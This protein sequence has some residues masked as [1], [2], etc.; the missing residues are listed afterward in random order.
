MFKKK[1]KQINTGQVIIPVGHP[2]PPEAHEVDAAYL[3][4][5]HF[6]CK[7]E[8]LL[9]TDDYKRKT[10]DIVMLGTLWEMKSPIGASKSTISNQF[11]VASKQARNII[12]DTRRTALSYEQIEKNVLNEFKMRSKTKRVLLINK[13]EKIIEIQK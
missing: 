11:K 7:V 13:F 2:N 3:L 10:A 1:K 6:N 4:A 8:F 9:P 12:I 5:C